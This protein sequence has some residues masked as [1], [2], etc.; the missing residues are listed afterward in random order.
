M[1]YV[2]LLL[3]YYSAFALE[4]EGRVLQADY[5]AVVVFENSSI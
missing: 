4:R 3:L 2:I 1:H 5:Q